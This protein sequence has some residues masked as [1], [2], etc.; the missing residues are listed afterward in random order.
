MTGT[1]V[2]VIPRPPTGLRVIAGS[3]PASASGLAGD[4]CRHYFVK[5]GGVWTCTMCGA[6]R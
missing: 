6:T 3:E 1:N 4:A 5:Q 2:S